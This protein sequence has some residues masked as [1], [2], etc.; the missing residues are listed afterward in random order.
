[1]NFLNFYTSSQICI[2]SLWCKKFKHSFQKISNLFSLNDYTT[3]SPHC[4]TFTLIVLRITNSFK[5][6]W[7]INI[8][9]S[10]QFFVSDIVISLSIKLSK[11]NP[12]TFISKSSILDYNS[13]YMLIR[14]ASSSD[15][16]FFQVCFAIDHLR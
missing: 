7:T 8:N 5:P 11:H 14:D 16:I 10:V 9:R 4:T 6:I 2:T 12:D 13:E 3:K 1:M 15:N